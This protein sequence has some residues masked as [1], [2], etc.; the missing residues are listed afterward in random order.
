MGICPKVSIDLLSQM[1]R[2]VLRCKELVERSRQRT[3]SLPTTGSSYGGSTNKRGP[4]SALEK[5]WAM[6]D[7]KHLDALI[8]RSFYSGGIHF[9]CNTLICNFKFSLLVF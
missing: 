4:A 3:V 5:S 8:A 1:R 9:H 2:D 7:R 6:E